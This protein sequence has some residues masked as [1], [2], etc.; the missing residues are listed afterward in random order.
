[1]EY[2]EQLA[3]EFHTGSLHE[4]PRLYQY[5]LTFGKT[6]VGHYLPTMV[7]R[8]PYVATVLYM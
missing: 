8:L 4:P 3:M 6:S 1:M 7:E 2:V 5:I